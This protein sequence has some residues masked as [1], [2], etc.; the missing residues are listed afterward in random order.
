MSM[1][2]LFAQ[3]SMIAS[4]CE[5]EGEA[6]AQ[7]GATRQISERRAARRFEA[8]ELQGAECDVVTI[9]SSPACLHAA[10]ARSNAGTRSASP[11]VSLRECDTRG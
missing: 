11:F 6:S 4:F 7:N 1:F 9:T 8:G 2:S 5:T 10:N 3:E